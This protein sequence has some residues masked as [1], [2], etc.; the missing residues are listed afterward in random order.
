MLDPQD[1]VRETAA[2]FGFALVGVTSA[3]VLAQDLLHLERWTTAGHH[4]GMGWM[5][6]NPPERADPRTLLSSVR[7][8]LTFAVPHAREAP[9]RPPRASGRV[10]RYAWGVDYHDVMIHRLRELAA[11]LPGVLGVPLRAKVAVD[12]SPLLERAMAARAG[13]GFF[14]KNTCLLLPRRGS[15]FLLGEILVDVELPNTPPSPVEG[16]GTC[17]RCL[18]ACPTDAFPAPFVLDA[19]RCISYLTIELRGS[20]PRDLRERLGDWVFGC[21]VCQEV[22][23][24]NRF[25]AE[26]AW[27]ELGAE[28]GV[29]AYV[30]LEQ[31]LAIRHDAAFQRAFARTP[32]LRP[33]RTG[34][35][36]NAAIVAANQ[37]ATACIPSLRRLLQD[38]DPVLREHALWAL[39]RLVGAEAHAA[40]SVAVNDED[41][42]VQQ[43]ARAVLEGDA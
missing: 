11:A 3:D 24:F 15:W 30:D 4:A 29:G 5:A 39:G 42:R 16:C 6:R 32:L 36:R 34:L 26:E 40:A 8:V 41:P 7:S 1:R 43:E 20:I 25:D 18:P 28:G 31:V 27:P 17:V 35:L 21:D 38:G 2:R 10:A 37:G 19:R 12:H 13:L 22:C 9:P 33:G 14:G 23:P